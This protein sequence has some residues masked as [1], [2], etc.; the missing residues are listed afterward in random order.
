MGDVGQGV[1]IIGAGRIG[2][3]WGAVLAATQDVEVTCIDIDED[4]VATLN[5]GTAPFSEPQLDEYLATAVESGTLAATTDPSAVTDHQYV[6]FAVNAPRNGMSE[7]LETVREYGP[8]LRDD[9]T[10][11]NRVTLPVDMIGRM[12]E[13]IAKHAEGDPTFAAFPERLAEGKAIEEIKSLPKIVGVDD[14]QGRESMHE[15]LRSFD[16]DI[17]FTDPETAMFVKLI[18]NSY[19]DALFAIANQIAYTADQLDL[20]AHKAI[21][22]ANYEYPRNDIPTPG[23]VGGKCLPKDPHF[24]TDERV[25]D[26]PTT[27]DLFNATRRTNAHLSSYTVTQVVRRQPSKVAMLGLSYKRG[28]GDT[29]NSPAKDIA[30]SLEAQGL[31]V[32]AYEPHVD[33]YDDLSGT[34]DGADVV[35][36]AVNHGEFEGL[37]PQINDLT[38]ENATVYDLWGALDRDKLTRTYDGFGIAGDQNETT[39]RAGHKNTPVKE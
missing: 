29:Y 1:A 6:A 34:L 26:Q 8:Y 13:T 37:E 10:V 32:V 17:K 30:D 21:S 22:L 36:L 18:D 24:L 7:F 19:R 20:D 28:V 16:A 4:R 25:C 11:V 33:G 23:P 9:H 38:A 15:L 14:E 35:I 12:R 39:S 27:P 3:P 31:P 5:S 2:V